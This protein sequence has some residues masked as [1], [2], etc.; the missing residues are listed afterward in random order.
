[1][2]A[3]I[4]SKNEFEIIKDSLQEMKQHLKNITSPAEHFVNNDQFVKLMGIS[5]RTAQVWRD[6][7]KIG[8][9]QEGK[10]IYYRMSDIEKFLD[11]HYIAAAEETNHSD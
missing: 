9:S 11:K 3:V 6:E 2:N 5:S 10:K 4:L 8:F 1:M 7:N